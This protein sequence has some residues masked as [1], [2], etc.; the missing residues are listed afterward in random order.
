[1]KFDYDYLLHFLGGM[2]LGGIACVTVFLGWSIVVPLVAVVGIGIFGYL[3]EKSQHE[4]H[5]LTLHQWVEALT[6]P[7][8]AASALISLL[9]A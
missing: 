7:A 2:G 3:R 5:P 6:W 4:F 1:M 9:W 8:G